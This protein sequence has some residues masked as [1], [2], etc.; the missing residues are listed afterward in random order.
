M[1]GANLVPS[2]PLLVS[3][4]GSIMEVRHSLPP[5][6]RHLRGG[7]TAA[8]LLLSMAAVDCL[9]DEQDR[10]NGEMTVSTRRLML[11]G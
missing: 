2:L 3:V 7:R 10:M 5:A 8:I 4:R 6:L 9:L 11:L 1:P